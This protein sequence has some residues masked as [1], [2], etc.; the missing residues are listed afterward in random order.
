ME[1]LSS[2][3]ICLAAGIPEVLEPCRTLKSKANLSGR[4]KREFISDEKKDASYWEKRR[5]NNEAA[6]RSREKR[7]FN[8]LVLENRV[9]A[10][11]DE[12]VRLRTEL[13]QLKLRFGLIS[14][15]SFVEK[16]QQLSDRSSLSRLYGSYSN[17]SS[18]AVHSDSETEQSS[19]DSAGMSLSKYSSQGSLS[20]M[21]DGS[22]R[23]SPIP[24]TFSEAKALS[25]SGRDNGFHHHMHSADFYNESIKALEAVEQLGEG[26]ERN[27]TGIRPRGGVILFRTGGFT[28][29]PQQAPELKAASLLP[30][31]PNREKPAPVEHGKET[32]S[33]ASYPISPPG[34]TATGFRNTILCSGYNAPA[35]ERCAVPMSPERPA[36][37]TL[38]DRHTCQ[39]L[40]YNHTGGMGQCILEAPKPM[41]LHDSAR[42]HSTF[43]EQADTNNSPSHPG[44]ASE[45]CPP[46]DI[47][48]TSEDSNAALEDVPSRAA[49][50]SPAPCVSPDLPA[51]VKMSS[52]P[53][54]LRL[55]HR[56]HS[57]GIPEPA[58]MSASGHQACPPNAELADRYLGAFEE[59]AGYCP[60][61]GT[62]GPSEVAAFLQRSWLYQT[63]AEACRP[64]A[65]NALD[66]D[67]ANCG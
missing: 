39:E 2:S 58:A 49:G 44:A 67:C 26:H 16:S 57:S 65:W 60:A 61:P 14:S 18:S 31:H 41:A 17:G 64:Q 34:P 10:L 5:K 12:N 37:A 56:A 30:G 59:P 52:L 36:T 47:S 25:R 23:D 46:S 32:A 4:R 19:H 43:S 53:H 13:L 22:S 35:V 33:G 38:P 20:D 29:D 54:K 24:P 40:S 8:D 55:K 21:S 11:N 51:D 48:G 45:G 3:S 15:A 27:P 28:I 63:Q 42:P 66:M 6:K 62:L 1:N 7:R 9:L 50:H